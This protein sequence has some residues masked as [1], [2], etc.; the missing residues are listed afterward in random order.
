MKPEHFIINEEET[1]LPVGYAIL[2]NNQYMFNDYL[3]PT[4]EPALTEARREKIKE[5]LNELSSEDYDYNQVNWKLKSKVVM[6]LIYQS[7]F[8]NKYFE[9]HESTPTFTEGIA[10]TMKCKCELGEKVNVSFRKFDSDTDEG[11]CSFI[12]ETLIREAIQHILQSVD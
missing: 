7:K 2:Y 12:M 11:Y 4:G 8:L 9:F 3:K 6:Q 1:D 5:L 10:A